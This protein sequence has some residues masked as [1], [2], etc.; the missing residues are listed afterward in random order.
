MT[1]ITFV[2]HSSRR[3]ESQRLSKLEGKLQHSGQFLKNL[4]S[5]FIALFPPNASDVCLLCRY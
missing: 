1:P 5:I 2:Y 4:F 3:M